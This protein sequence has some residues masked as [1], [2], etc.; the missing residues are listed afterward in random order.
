MDR[1]GDDRAGGTTSHPVNMPRSLQRA[2]ALSFAGIVCALAGCDGG[3]EPDPLGRY[4]YTVST[5]RVT[6][7]RGGNAEFF[8]EADEDSTYRYLAFSIGDSLEFFHFN[9]GDEVLTPA[10]TYQVTNGVFSGEPHRMSGDLYNVQPW[11]VWVKEGA[12]TITLESVALDRIRGRFDIVLI[13]AQTFVE[14]GRLTGWFDAK[15]GE[16]YGSGPGFR[17]SPRR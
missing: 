11:P 4:Q 6:T 1:A 8:A 13:N 7:Y 2:L 15:P 3:N 17:V 9:T 14:V 16:R 5:N 10:G 12:S